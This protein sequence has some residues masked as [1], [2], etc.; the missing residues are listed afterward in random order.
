MS[1][2]IFVFYTAVPP[3][4]PDDLF[5]RLLATLPVPVAAKILQYKLPA[6]RAL[7]LTGK[8]LLRHAFISCEQ[9]YPS[10]SHYVCDESHQPSFREGK[11]NFSISH[12]QGMTVCALGE[13]APAGVDIEMKRP[14]DLTLMKEYFDSRSVAEIESSADP[15]SSFFML[16]TEKEAA[17]KAAG[18]G[19]ADLA[20][21]EVRKQ[22]NCLLIK[23][24][25][26]YSRPV[27]PK[28]NYFITVASS[29]K[30]DD[31]SVEEVSFEALAEEA[32][33]IRQRSL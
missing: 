19:I 6:D 18:T 8:L 31:I 4:I 15:L 20:L 33:Q 26:Y 2:K 10:F 24:A 12:S 32:G 30:I 27:I 14:V 3:L 17:L 23:G 21:S 9:P 25:P 5:N 29:C 16:W 13:E 28:E 7:R 1:N 22:K 11:T